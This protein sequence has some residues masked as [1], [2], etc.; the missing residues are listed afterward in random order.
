M[1]KVGRNGNFVP[2]V[3]MKIRFSRSRSLQNTVEKVF[4]I[5]YVE[6][7]EEASVLVKEYG[8]HRQWYIE[9]ED[10]IVLAYDNNREL[11]EGLRV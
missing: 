9:D 7:G 10:E 3:G 8:L 11:P 4:I 1:Y 6:N 5:Q 2:V